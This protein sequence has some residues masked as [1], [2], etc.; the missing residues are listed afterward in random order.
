MGALETSVPAPVASKFA[1]A[2]IQEPVLRKAMDDFRG[3]KGGKAPAVEFLQRV[4]RLAEF[5][6]VVSQFRSEPGF[7]RAFLQLAKTPEIDGV[8]RGVKAALKPS[9]V[10]ASAGAIDRSG[11]LRRL[12]SLSSSRGLASNLPGGASFRTTRGAGLVSSASGAGPGSGAPASATGGNAGAESSRGTGGYNATG[13]E[14]GQQGGEALTKLVA[15]SSVDQDVGALVRPLDDFDE[16][17][18]EDPHR[19]PP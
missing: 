12:S 4:A 18:A 17:A 1:K 19:A 6:Q 14:S 11:A 10:L 5:R 8:I 15:P 9:G 13:T 3:E 16:L 7:Q 2:F